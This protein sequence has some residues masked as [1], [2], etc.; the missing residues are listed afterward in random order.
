MRAVLASA[1]CFVALTVAV[2]AQEQAAPSMEQALELVQAEDWT[3]A[4][5][6]LDA[7]TAREPENGRAWYELGNVR[8]NLERYEKTILAWTR[9]DELGFAPQ[10]TRF[11]LARAH[12]LAGHAD[13][14][15]DWL[16]RA[17]D[18]GFAQT[19]GLRDEP[20]LS[21]LRD[22]PRFPQ[23]VERAEQ[24]AHPCR[25]DPRFKE[26]D[27]WIGEW[28]VVDPQGNAVGR[29]SIRRQ[30]DGC[31]LLESWTGN[32][33]SV[34]QSINYVDPG[35]G[36][37]VQIWVDGRGGLISVSG[38]LEDGSMCLTGEHVRPRGT[39]QPFRGTWTPLPD[40]RVRQHLEQS[41]DGGETWYT[42][43]DGYYVRREAG[44]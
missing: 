44:D 29:N 12:A 19:Q 6:V 17:L 16:G 30:I 37:W 10:A 27:F 41:G 2:L 35:S 43:F 22:D 34:G 28:D 36:Q 21:D 1:C 40:G 32:G 26:F 38:G 31:M 33:G 7:I 5:E 23:A 39:G 3:R 8:F 42:W 20:A 11:G 14:A 15:F 25:H 9:A 4:A 24:N 13:E 18:A